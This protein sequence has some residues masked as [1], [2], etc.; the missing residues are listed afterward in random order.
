MDPVPA[1]T[2]S[3]VARFG[4][5]SPSTMV[6]R[7]RASWPRLRIAAQRS[8]EEPIGLKIPL[9]VSLAGYVTGLEI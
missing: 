6:R 3:T 1:A 9:A 7:Q 8:Y 5:R 2:S 4:S